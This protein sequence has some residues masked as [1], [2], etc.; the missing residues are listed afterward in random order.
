MKRDMDL[1]RNILLDLET[2]NG[3]FSTS[4]LETEQLSEVMIGHHIW[5]L[6]DAGYI[7]GVE[8]RELR[9]KLPIAMPI[10]LTWKGHEFLAAARN[11][12][13]WH[14]TTRAIK[15]KI[16]AASMDVLMGMLERVAQQQLG[17]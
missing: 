9:D 13:V 6:K 14:Q 3:D 5:L 15:T 16:G 8:T 7:V 1:I 4:A 10:C 12:N 11:D 2:S 17:F